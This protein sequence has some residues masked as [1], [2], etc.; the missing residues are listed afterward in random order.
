MFVFY[1]IIIINA[2]F[3]Q[4]YGWRTAQAH[5]VIIKRLC[6]MFMACCT[7]FACCLSRGGGGGGGRHYRHGLSYEY[8]IY[9]AENHIISKFKVLILKYLVFI[10]LHYYFSF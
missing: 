8:A 9:T 4:I 5:L 10:K 7:F 2:I 1:C 3:L 6:C